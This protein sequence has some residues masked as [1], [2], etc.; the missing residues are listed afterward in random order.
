MI[1]KFGLY[2]TLALVIAF[3]ASEG[4]HA[5]VLLKEPAARMATNR[6]N[7]QAEVTR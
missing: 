7:A 2:L 3:M 4:L 6:A 5:A 1:R